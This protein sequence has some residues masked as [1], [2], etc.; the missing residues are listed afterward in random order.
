MGD[1]FNLALAVWENI[2]FDKTV[3]NHKPYVARENL[4]AAINYLRTKYFYTIAL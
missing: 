1:C 4:V 2:G 3:V